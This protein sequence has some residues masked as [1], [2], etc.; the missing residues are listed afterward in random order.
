MKPMYNSAGGPDATFYTDVQPQYIFSIMHYCLGLTCLAEQP[1][2][3]NTMS[4]HIKP[5]WH[6][7]SKGSN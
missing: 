1:F 2:L 5:Q 7:N 3:V 6:S 4:S